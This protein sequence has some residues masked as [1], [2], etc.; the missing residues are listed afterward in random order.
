MK[1]QSVSSYYDEK[2]RL[3][4]SAGLRANHVVSGLTDGLLPELELALAELRIESPTEWLASVKR[5][6]IAMTRQRQRTAFKYQQPRR[7]DDGKYMQTRQQDDL[8]KTEYKGFTI[9]CISEDIYRRLQLQLINNSV[10]TIRQVTSSTQTLGR[11]SIS[12]KIG[13]TTKKV[14][15]HVLRGMKAEL[16]LG[17]DYASDHNLAL[18]LSTLQ[19]TTLP[20]TIPSQP[21]PAP[22]PPGVHGQNYPDRDSLTPTQQRALD[23]LLEKYSSIFSTSQ[24]D[25]GSIT[26]E[27]HSITLLNNVPIHRPPYRASQADR[28]EIDKQGESLLGQG[29]IRPSLSP[30]GSP[31]VVAEK[32]GEGRTRMCIDYRRL[33]AITAANHQPIPRI[34]DVLDSLG[35][36]RYFSALDITSGYWHV[37]TNRHDIS[38]TAFVTPTGHYEWLVMPFGLKNAPATFQRAVKAIIAKHNLRNVVNYFDDIVVHVPTFEAHLT[39]MMA[40]SEHCKL[41]MSN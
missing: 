25:I 4:E 9:S 11:V 40:S 19:L 20:C 41:K 15:V 35:P 22:S 6:E 31:L 33:N 1:D 28:A 21:M 7:T 18:D 17:L 10:I 16:L 24:T 3:G 8:P 27:Q 34:D 29:F 13:E 32:K 14:K 39:Y 38:K 37:P 36:S 2:R 23:K 12:L 30:Y 5:V 26:T